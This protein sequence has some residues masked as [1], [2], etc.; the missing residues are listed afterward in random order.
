MRKIRDILRLKHSAGLSLRQIARSLN[1]SVGVVSKYLAAARAAGLSWPLEEGL[2]DE[3]LEGLLSGQVAT[4][5][6]NPFA[7]PDFPYIH[8]E[9]KRK[10]VTRLLLWEEYAD[11]FPLNH[12]RYT[13]FCV[14]YKQWRRRLSPTMRQLHKAGEKMFV[15][16]AGQ[17]V[18][19]LDPHSGLLHRAQIF[20]AVLGASN[21]CFAEATLTQTLPDWIG[22]H[23]RAFNFFGGVTDLIVP[24]NVKSGVTKASRYEPRLNRTYEEMAAHYSTAILP[25]RPYKPRDK[26]KAEVSVQL[27]ERWILA[28]L[29]NLTFF[30]LFDLNEAIRSLIHQLNLR[31]F[32]KIEG[33]R[34]SLFES[35]DKPHLKPLP[36]TPYEYGEWMKARVGE[37][38][39]VCVDGHFYSVPHSLTRKQIDVKLTAKVVEILFGGK[40]VASHIRSAVKG[41]CTTLSEHMPRAHREQKEWGVQRLIQWSEGVGTHTQQV[42][43]HLLTSK[44]HP[45]QGLRSGL[46]LVSLGRRYGLDRVEAACRR[47]CEIGSLSLTS[48]ESILKSGLDRVAF[49]Q[50]EKLQAEIYL[51][52]NVRGADYYLQITE[53]EKG[54]KVNADA[55]N[56][57]ETETDEADRDGRS[58]SAADGATG[59]SRSVV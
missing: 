31:P 10:G 44:P 14:L 12:Y 52:E 55:T 53:E 45:Q 2:S 51:H 58:A 4:Q 15:D 40:R 47:A 32:R 46:G 16:Y 59:D 6:S 28:R 48:V 3:D 11:A 50:A 26:A 36:L 5:T 18:P 43:S 54:E 21:Y 23:Q 38:Y 25:A 35:L 41:G 1:L 34:L 8:L 17:T 19:L 56:H 27:V 57:T 22:S 7:E 33:C 30:S 13:Q 9:L 37:D 39:H 42:I 49:E 29:R 24:D 20:V